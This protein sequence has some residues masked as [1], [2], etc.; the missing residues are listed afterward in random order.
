MPDRQDDL[1]PASELGPFADALKRL[2]PQP[3]HLSRDALLFEAGKATVSPRMKWAWPSATAAFAGISFVLAAFLMSPGSPSVQYVDRIVYVNP[4]AESDGPARVATKPEPAKPNKV[5]ESEDLSEAAKAYQVRRDV[6]RWGIDML[7]E[8]KSD[9]GRSPGVAQ[10][11]LPRW[12]DQPPG[13]GT[14]AIP[15]ARPMQPPKK[16]DDHK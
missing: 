1:N 13:A 10:R 11:D 3:A 15:P 14:Y 9:G 8:S 7:P 4:P 2:A 12:L 5:S 6:L 16:E